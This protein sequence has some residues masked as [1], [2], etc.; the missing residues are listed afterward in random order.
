MRSNRSKTLTIIAGTLLILL[1]GLIAIAAYYSFYVYQQLF[2][3]KDL[4][5]EWSKV[6][7][8]NWDIIWY[9]RDFWMMSGISLLSGILIFW[10]QFYNWSI[11]FANCI[12]ICIG[13]VKSFYFIHFV[14]DYGSNSNHSEIEPYLFL[15]WLV[16]LLISVFV[17]ITISQKPWTKRLPKG[18]KKW[19]LTIGIATIM[20]SII[21]L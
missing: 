19:Y 7:I 11:V 10:K 1:G 17:A 9:I 14:N 18:R 3:L 12:L 6:E 4:F 8:T 20:L 21:Y 5:P 2:D 15:I 13:S 16:P